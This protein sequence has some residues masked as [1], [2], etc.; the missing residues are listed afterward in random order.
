MPTY[1]ALLV[2][3]LVAAGNFGGMIALT[4]FLGPKHRSPV[5][6]EPFECGSIPVGPVTGKVHVRFYMVAMLFIVFDIETVMLYPWAVIYLKDLKLFGLME[7]AF[8][9]ATLTF[10]LVYVWKRGALEWD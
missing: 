9:I 8:F 10:G 1:A 5:K 3:L 4:S 2:F 6:D 7:M